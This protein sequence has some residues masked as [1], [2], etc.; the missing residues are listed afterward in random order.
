[1]DTNL[2]THKIMDISLKRF[3][4]IDLPFRCTV[5]AKRI[6]ARVTNFTPKFEYIGTDNHGNMQFRD[7]R[8]DRLI[9]ENIADK[10]NEWLKQDF[11]QSFDVEPQG[12]QRYKLTLVKTIAEAREYSKIIDLD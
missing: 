4:S 7:Q 10:G 9:K 3:S 2:G 6:G 5:T 12:G 11:F 8:L 1:M